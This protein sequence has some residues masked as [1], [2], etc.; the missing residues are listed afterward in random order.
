MVSGIWIAFFLLRK[1]NL[2]QKDWK[3]QIKKIRLGLDFWHKIAW[4][5]DLGKKNKQ[6]KKTKGICILNIFR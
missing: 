1:Q 5:W 6:T 2:G 3:S 4:E